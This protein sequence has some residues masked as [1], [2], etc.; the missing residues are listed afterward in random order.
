M[1]ARRA[2][3]HNR[4]KNIGHSCRQ[5]DGGYVLETWCDALKARF[6][7]SSPRAICHAR[8]S[9]DNSIASYPLPGT[10]TRHLLV[11]QPSAQTINLTWA[12]RMQR[13]RQLMLRMERHYAIK[14]A[15]PQPPPPPCPAFV[16]ATVLEADYAVRVNQ[17]T[18]V[19][20]HLLV[21]TACIFVVFLNF[22]RQFLL[23]VMAV[24]CTS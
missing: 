7:S 2:K 5:R 23:R 16:D 18:R 14:V 10:T 17:R 13:T 4:Q 19:M 12:I 11:L 21:W 8:R 9:S 20:F 24:W 15:E 22:M 1:L 3:H 6:L